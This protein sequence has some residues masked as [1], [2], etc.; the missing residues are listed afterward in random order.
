LLSAQ[1]ISLDAHTFC[2]NCSEFI[3]TPIVHHSDTISASIVSPY[4]KTVRCVNCRYTCHYRCSKFV[5]INCQKIS[6]MDESDSDRKNSLEKQSSAESEPE[7]DG[8]PD[9]PLFVDRAELQAQIQKYNERIAYRGSGLGIYLLDDGRTFRG[10]LRVHMNLTRPINVIAGTRPPSI[11]DIINEEEIASRRT[12]TT[13]YMP[14][15]TVKNIHINSLNTSVDVI[16]AMLKK[17]KM[18]DNRQK[19]ALYKKHGIDDSA[20]PVLSRIADHEHPLRIALEWLDSDDKQIVL[21]ENDT[22]DVNWDEFLLPELN[23]FLKILDREEKE[24]FD[25]VKIKYEVLRTELEKLIDYKSMFSDP[26]FV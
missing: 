21:Q 3:W 13:F 10:F 17:F 23:N 25:Q 16:K 22:A 20:S 1:I 24:H 15:D 18:V 6:S 7:V 5:R 8:R 26:V 14:R 2:D 12:L 4:A 11:Y 19:F 9:S